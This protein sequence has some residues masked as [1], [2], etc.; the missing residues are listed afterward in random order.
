MTTNK[1]SKVVW[2][3]SSHGKAQIKLDK[4]TMTV[5]D[6]KRQ[7]SMIFSKLH[8]EVQPRLREI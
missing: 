7:H 3:K 8:E 5:E 4:H 6:Y 1:K 2:K